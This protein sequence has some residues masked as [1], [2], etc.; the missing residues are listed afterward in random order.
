M[1]DSLYMEDKLL[2]YIKEIR[3]ISYNMGHKEIGNKR[4]ARDKENKL[5]NE[6][7]LDTR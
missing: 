3:D 6:N 4:Y 5:D 7:E 2:S 1:G